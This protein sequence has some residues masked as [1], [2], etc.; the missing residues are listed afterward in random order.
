MD[1]THAEV[2]YL[3]SETLAENVGAWNQ[4][5]QKA[6]EKTYLTPRKICNAINE[7]AD[8]AGYSQD[9]TPEDCEL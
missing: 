5:L 4:F 2:Y 7:A 9:L 1:K 3:M 8:V 6:N